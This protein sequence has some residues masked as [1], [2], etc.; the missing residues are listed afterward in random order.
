MRDVLLGL[1]VVKLGDVDDDAPWRMTVDAWDARTEKILRYQLTGHYNGWPA[2][3]PERTLKDIARV[4]ANRERADEIAAELDRL[5][6]EAIAKIAPIMEQ[7]FRDQA[8]V[9][10][11]ERVLGFLDREE[12]P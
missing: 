5:D 6:R 3:P 1:E 2:G 11:G 7:L 9:I 12:R 10:Y 4:Q 8:V